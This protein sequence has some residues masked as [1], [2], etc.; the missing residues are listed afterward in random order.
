MQGI[1]IAG[2]GAPEIVVADATDGDIIQAGDGNN[3][4]FGDNGRITAARADAPQIPGL[5]ITL[6]LVETI[7]SL[8][9]GSDSIT[10]GTG[11]TSCSAASTRMSRR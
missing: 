5:P 8:I 9:G 3:I 11:T 4:V 10:T 6:G 7:E 2:N 1:H